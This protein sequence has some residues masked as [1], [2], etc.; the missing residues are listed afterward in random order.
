VAVLTPLRLADGSA[1]FVDRGW[2][3]SP[4]AR[5]IDPTRTREADTATV[6]GLGVRAPRAP[7]DVDPVALADSLPYPLAAFVIQ[8]LPAGDGFSDSPLPVRRWPAAELDDGPHLS[9]AIQWFAFAAIAL[10]GMVAVVR[11]AREPRGR[12]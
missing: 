3:P 12:P 2:V 9:Y 10:G 7:G 11:Q 1:V 5:A 4:D 8:W 6:T